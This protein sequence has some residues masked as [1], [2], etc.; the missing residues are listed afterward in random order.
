MCQDLDRGVGRLAPSLG[1]GARAGV[2]RVLSALGGHTQPSPTAPCNYDLNPVLTRTP[3]KPRQAGFVKGTPPIRESLPGRGRSRGR[4]PRAWTAG[5]TRRAGGLPAHTR[6]HA[7]RGTCEL[8]TY[9]CTHVHTSAVSRGHTQDVACRQASCAHVHTLGYTHAPRAHDLQA[10]AGLRGPPSHPR[11]RGLVCL[12]QL[13][14]G[15]AE[16][17]GAQESPAGPRSPQLPRAWGET[18]PSHPALPDSRWG[19]VC[20]WTQLWGGWQD[21]PAPAHRG[22]QS[23]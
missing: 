13:V 22:P 18:S 20:S 17:P 8:T 4:G 21:A 5:S 6:A 7:C 11:P 12:A 3:W 1:N 19:P 10:H 16:P 14:R 2:L 23:N 9:T 15:R